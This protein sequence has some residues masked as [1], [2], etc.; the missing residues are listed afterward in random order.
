MARDWYL[1]G[2]VRTL[3]EVSKLVDGLSAES[4]NTYLT[5]HPPRDFTIVT[6]G[7]NTLEVPG[8]G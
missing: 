3:D 4:I 1:L 8:E 5:Q 6:L 7:R 2:R